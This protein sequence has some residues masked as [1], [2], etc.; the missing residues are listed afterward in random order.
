MHGDKVIVRL[1]EPIEGKKDEGEV[2]R[3]L[4]RAN[5]TVVGRFRGY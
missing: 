3:I 2:I 4:E 5:E 1:A